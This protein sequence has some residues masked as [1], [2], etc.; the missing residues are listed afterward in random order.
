MAALITTA[1]E[2]FI[3]NPFDY[4]W[5]PAHGGLFYFLDADGHRYTAFILVL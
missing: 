3:N 2:K 4:G 5:D 1:I